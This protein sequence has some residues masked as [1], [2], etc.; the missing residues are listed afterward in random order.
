MTARER[1]LETIRF[2]KLDRAFRWEAPAVWPATIKRWHKE[3]LPRHITCT[4][5]TDSE[6][7]DHFEMDRLV[8]LPFEGGWIGDPYWPMFETSI[9]DDDGEHLTIQDTDGIIKKM[10]K[11]DPDTSMPQFLRFPVESRS[12]YEEKIRWRLDYAS[13]ERFPENW[14]Q[15]TAQ[16]AKRDYPIGM[17]VI[18]PFG[19]LRNLM[20]VEILMYTLHD[21]PQLIHDIMAHWRSFYQGFI[22]LVSKEVVPDF[23]MIW[24][25]MCYRSGPLV[26][27]RTYRE[28]MAPYLGDVISAARSSGIA[29]IVVDNDGD[30]LSV[31]PI[32][33]ECGANAF[34]PFEVQS[35]M[36]VVAIREEFGKRF[37]I[38]GGIDKRAL[39]LGEDVVRRE[40]G[41]KVPPMLK[42]GGYIP[43]LDHSVPTDVSLSMFRY[44]L[45][46][47]RGVRP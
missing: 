7:Y 24:E 38:I 3:G 6:I 33:L 17:F 42:S 1:F 20:G 26:S 21:Q 23:L 39:A 19:H 16:Y 29:G 45:E 4:N 18:G 31:L 8:W 12:D 10:K 34:Y 28:F 2:G 25:D 30:C 15:L 14:P 44:Y 47:V 9:L 22:G 41:A 36:D 43:M 40:I 27:P 37:A 5:I 11:E 13:K 46:C 35:G 32:Y